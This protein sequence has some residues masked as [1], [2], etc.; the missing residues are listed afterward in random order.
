MSVL[1]RPILAIRTGSEYI[2]TSAVPAG[3]KGH[4]YRVLG[5]TRNATVRVQQLLVLVECL[6]GPDEGMQ[7]V[8]TQ[9]NMAIRY[10]LA[11]Q[12]ETVLVGGIHPVE[13]KPI[14]PDSKDWKGT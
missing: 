5:L 8:V 12:P 6:S 14:G 1:K 10:R 13:E 9:W 4:K 7:F 11:D 2:F 3:R